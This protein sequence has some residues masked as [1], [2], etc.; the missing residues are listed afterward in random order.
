M[1]CLA[2]FTCEN[3]VES[4]LDVGRVQ[5]RSLDEGK[6]VLLGEGARVLRRH[7]AQVAQ[8]RLVAH[9]H[10]HDVGVGVVAKLP[11]PALHVLVRQV[12]GDVVDEQ[13][14]DGAPVVTVGKFQLTSKIRSEISS[15]VTIRTKHSRQA[16]GVSQGLLGGCTG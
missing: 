1:T 9:Q 10:D 6:V 3:V 7:G 11:E 15:L 14:T 5:R 4:R 13:S 12:L 8:V 16:S 2:S